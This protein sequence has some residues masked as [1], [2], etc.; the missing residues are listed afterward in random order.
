MLFNLLVK[1]CFIY[2]EY[3]S[4]PDDYEI[5]LDVLKVFSLLENTYGVWEEGSKPTLVLQKQDLSIVKTLA[6]SYGLTWELP[7]SMKFGSVKTRS[8]S[9][10]KKRSKVEV[11][12]AKMKDLV[13]TVAKNK[14]LI[15]DLVDEIVDLKERVAELENS[16]IVLSDDEEEE[17]LEGEEEKGSDEEEDGDDSDYK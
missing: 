3:E 14:I 12:D 9:P 17:G 4:F 16:P 2:D 5:K 13:E 7:D 10:V 8:N 11:S 15:Q 1:F 6:D